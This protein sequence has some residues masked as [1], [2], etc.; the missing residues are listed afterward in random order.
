MEEEKAIFRH[1]W[2]SAI[3]MNDFEKIVFKR[4]NLKRQ[5]VAIGFF[6]TNIKLPLRRKVNSKI[7]TIK[8]SKHLS[9]RF[10]FSGIIWNE[11]KIKPLYSHLICHM[12]RMLDWVPDGRVKFVVTEKIVFHNRNL[13]RAKLWK[14]GPSTF[15]RNVF[16]KTKFGRATVWKWKGLDGNLLELNKPVLTEKSEFE[17]QGYSKVTAFFLKFGLWGSLYKERS[18]PFFR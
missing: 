4:P 5:G 1:F 12:V 3:W 2:P 9:G 14:F 10:G 8:L 11:K 17:Y 18:P 13:W 6:M 7:E 15:W 16:E